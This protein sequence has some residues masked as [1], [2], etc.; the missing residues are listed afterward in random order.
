MYIVRKLGGKEE[1]ILNVK[2]KIFLPSPRSDLKDYWRWARLT[3]PR[4]SRKVPIE[5]RGF[6]IL[7]AFILGFRLGPL[8][9][10]FTA[11]KALRS[12]LFQ[13]YFTY[14]SFEKNKKLKLNDFRR[15]LYINRAKQNLQR[16]MKEKILCYGG[17]GCHC[18]WHHLVN[19]T[20][21]SNARKSI[22]LDFFFLC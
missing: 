8:N 5:I 3:R 19:S 20:L 18:S 7:I 12:L 17:G 9:P 2:L 1:Q 22:I 14:V 15:N 6:R 21:I 13:F 10:N 16:K 4:K 11:I